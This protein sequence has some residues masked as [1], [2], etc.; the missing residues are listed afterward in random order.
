MIKIFDLINKVKELNPLVLHYTNNVTITD[1]ANT[2]LAIGASPL[3]SFSY[4]EVEDIVKVASSIVINIGTMNS[5]LLDLFILAGKTA[6]KYNKPVIL[7]PVGVFATEARTK[8]TNKLL[9]E[10][11][12]DVIRGNIS[13]IQFLGGLDVKGKGVDS[14]DDGSDSTHIVESVARKLDCVVVASGKIDL[15][16]DGKTTYKI[17][18]GSSKLK[19]IT[20]TG[21]MSTSLIA[22][23][24]PCTDKIID[25][26][27]MGTIAMSLSGELADKE[28][29][30]IGT[31]K[32]LLFDNLFLLNKE[33]LEKYS[34]IEV[35]HIEQNI[36]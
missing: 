14:F 21:C 8:L 4:E 16:S 36:V 7:D 9:N 15:I 22:S 27:V 32:T 10:V 6:N 5:E 19:F 20:G 25:A 11:R 34:K 28:N 17:H 26:A 30:P 29:S 12:F 24:L 18:N 3:M 23:F 31:Y 33:I 2:T 35:K 1:C 13:E